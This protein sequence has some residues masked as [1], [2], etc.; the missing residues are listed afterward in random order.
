MKRKQEKEHEIRRFG[1]NQRCLT[2]PTTIYNLQ[3]FPHLQG[4]QTAKGPK[5]LILK[6]YWVFPRGQSGWVV[7]LVTHRHAVPGLGMHR[8]TPQLPHIPSWSAEVQI[9]LHVSSVNF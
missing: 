5:S 1:K 3:Q 4:T 2:T 9:Y 8:L 6:G 7:K